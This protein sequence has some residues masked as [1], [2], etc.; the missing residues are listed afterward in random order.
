MLGYRPARCLFD[1][2]VPSTFGTQMMFVGRTS[3]VDWIMRDALF[4]IAPVGGYPAA[5]EL[6]GLVPGD[7]PACEVFRRP[8]T[9]GAGVNWPA[10]YR[11]SQNSPPGAGSREVPCHGGRDRSVFGEVSGHIISAQQRGKEW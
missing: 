6:A 3:A 2:V 11:I 4:H 10:R 8:V 1:L 9:G 7:H 5:G